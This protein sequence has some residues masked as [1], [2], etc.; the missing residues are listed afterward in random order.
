MQKNGVQSDVIQS[1]WFFFCFCFYFSFF[2]YSFLFFLFFVFIHVHSCELYHS[3]F[4]F[5]FLILHASVHHFA[6]KIVIVER[7][8]YVIRCQ[9]IQFSFALINQLNAITSLTMLN[10]HAIKGETSSP[11]TNGKRSH[12]KN[13]AINPKFGKKKAVHLLRGLSSPVMVCL[14][15][16][17]FIPTKR[18]EKRPS[19]FHL[20]RTR[21][22]RHHFLQLTINFTSTIYLFFDR[23]NIHIFFPVCQLEIFFHRFTLSRFGDRTLSLVARTFNHYQRVTIALRFACKCILPFEKKCIRVL[24]ANF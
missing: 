7:L 6:M 23:E 8:F 1:W 13:V 15:K 5:L 16:T 4:S 18:I 22:N 24:S 2:L 9:L 3:N 20:T 17:R 19:E 21:S 10:W 12:E 14:T 11:L